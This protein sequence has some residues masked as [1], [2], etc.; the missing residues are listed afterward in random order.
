MAVAWQS[1]VSGLSW[2]RVD[3]VPVF[4]RR[5]GI[6]FHVLLKET[7]PSEADVLGR[8]SFE[9]ME[10]ARTQGISLASEATAGIS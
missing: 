8:C 5:D 2:V 4:G 9:E 6:V 7:I 3:S 1:V 10:S